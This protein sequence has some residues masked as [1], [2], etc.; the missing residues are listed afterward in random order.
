[1]YLKNYD[2]IEINGGF[3]LVSQEDPDDKFAPIDNGLFKP[4]DVFKVEHNGW[5]TFV[6]NDYEDAMANEEDSTL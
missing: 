5:L 1:M 3:R 2:I 4:G 6:A